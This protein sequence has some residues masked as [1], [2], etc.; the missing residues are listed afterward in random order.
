MIQ[1]IL[2]II[3]VLLIAIGTGLLT[4]RAWRS[5][6]RLPKWSGTILGGL[7]TLLCVLVAG[8]A[9]IGLWRIYGPKTNPVPEIQVADTPEQVARGEQLAQ[10][11]AGCHASDRTLPLAGGH[12]NDLAGFGVLV[13]PNLTPAGELRNWSDGEIIRAIREGVH[14]SGRGLILMPSDQYRAMSDEDVQALVAYLRSQPAVD[15]PTPANELNLLGLLMVGAGFL[16][17]SP[18]PAITQPI[19]T[20]PLADALEHGD[21]LIELAGCREC[22]GADLQGGTSQFLP[23][24]PNLIGLI[25]QG[26][27]NAEQFLATMRT[28]VTPY[29]RTLN[30]ELMPWKSYDAAFQDEELLTIYEYIWSASPS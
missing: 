9:T 30:P 27:W 18:Q 3:L 24:G 20:P 23:I 19:A 6:Q 13:V 1:A 2:S 25:Q 4:R 29:G 5:P 11:C 10:L 22:H 26:N 16:P 15:N 17:M 21:Y 12:H 7:L 14:Q 8:V 28:G